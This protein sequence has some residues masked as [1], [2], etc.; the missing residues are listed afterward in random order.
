MYFTTCLCISAMIYKSVGK[1]WLLTKTCKVLY[2][3]SLYYCHCIFIWQVV[4]TDLMGNATLTTR[5]FTLLPLPVGDNLWAGVWQ[6]VC[7]W[8][9]WVVQVDMNDAS[10]CHIIL[11]TIVYIRSTYMCLI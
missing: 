7:M 5:V 11:I 9:F 8:S 6:L 1:L 2:L 10:D 3:V 4:S